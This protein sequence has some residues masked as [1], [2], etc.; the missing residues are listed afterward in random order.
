MRQTLR[1]LLAAAVGFV[2]VVAL[3][4]L[5]TARDDPGIAPAPD[6]AATL[7]APAER[8]DGPLT[9]RERRLLEAGAV[10]LLYGDG[11]PPAPLVAL[12]DELSG[13]PDPAVERA[14]Q[15]VILRRADVD[16]VVALAWARTLRVDRADDERL[17]AFAS[18]WLGR[19]A[20]PSASG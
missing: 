10:F 17:R 20:D 14:G 8:D 7:G 5:L 9:A 2:A 11:R 15:A 19:G 1:V 18:Y 4:G 13:P 6:E 3:I 16:G 12:R